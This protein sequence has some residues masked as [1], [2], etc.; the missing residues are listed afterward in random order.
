METMIFNIFVIQFPWA[1]LAQRQRIFIFV[2]IRLPTQG[3]VFHEPVCFDSPYLDTMAVATK[4]PGGVPVVV[5]M[6]LRNLAAKEQGKV[7]ICHHSSTNCRVKSQHNS[8]CK[9]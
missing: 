2:Y 3:R 4:A 9:P 5:D 1:C 6:H 8:S 7:Q